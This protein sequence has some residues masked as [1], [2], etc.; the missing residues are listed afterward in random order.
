M[1][2]KE[3]EEQ[4]KAFKKRMGKRGLTVYDNVRGVCYSY[5]RRSAI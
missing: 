3:K 2:K 1:T 4:K 5:L